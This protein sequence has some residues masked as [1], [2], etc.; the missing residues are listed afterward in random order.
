V[1]TRLREGWNDLVLKVVNRGGGW[2]FACRIRQPDGSALEG[3]KL[4]AR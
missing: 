1:K 2:G 4:E 3:L